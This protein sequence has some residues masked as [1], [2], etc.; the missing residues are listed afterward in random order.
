M[1]VWYEHNAEGIR[2]AFNIHVNYYNCI[3][4]IF[5]TMMY[6]NVSVSYFQ[7]AIDLVR[8]LSNEMSKMVQWITFNIEIMG[9]VEGRGTG[10]NF[11]L[12]RGNALCPN[13][14][15][16]WEHVHR[17]NVVM[18]FSFKYLICVYFSKR[19]KDLFLTLILCTCSP[20]GL[21]L[22]QGAS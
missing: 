12:L 19:G 8:S 22:G 18:V 14:N 10:L 1:R 16:I 11:C 20:N 3:L 4:P 9:F 21:G 2:L 7:Y 17:I 15:R 13:P 6:L 5:V